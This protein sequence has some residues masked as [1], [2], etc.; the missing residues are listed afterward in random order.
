MPAK[1][2]YHDTVRSA[3]EKD[4]WMITDDPLTLKWGIKDLFVDFGAQKLL[5]AQKNDIKIAVEVKSFIGASP[6]TDL[7]KGLGQYI[8]YLDI[9]ARIQPDRDLYLAI[10]EETFSEIF[11]E[12]I[13]QLLLENKR[14]RLL[15]VN[16][17]EEVIVQWIP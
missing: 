9:L 6:M 11:E 8:L 2:T 12:P 1:D 3:L 15:V 14:K 4:G 16:P 10:R 17:E 7:Q 13:G 5:A